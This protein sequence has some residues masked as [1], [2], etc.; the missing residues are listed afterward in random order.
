VIVRRAMVIF[1]GGKSFLKTSL[2]GYITPYIETWKTECIAALPPSRKWRSDSKSIPI[3]FK[4]WPSL[5]FLNAI[6]D[7]SPRPSNL[8][9]RAPSSGLCYYALC[10][11]ESTELKGVSCCLVDIFEPICTQ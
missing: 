3:S 10:F 8:S 1:N 6:L 9:F 7:R 2:P 11:D 5:Y 4:G